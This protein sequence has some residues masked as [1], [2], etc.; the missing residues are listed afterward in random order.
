MQLAHGSARVTRAAVSVVPPS[1]TP[2][3]E[4]M[5]QQCKKLAGIAPEYRIM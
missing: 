5:G 1:A 2:F 4:A 3:G